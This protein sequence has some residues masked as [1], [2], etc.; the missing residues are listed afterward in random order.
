MKLKLKLCVFFIFFVVICIFGLENVKAAKVTG[1]QVT[2]LGESQPVSNFNNYVSTLYTGKTISEVCY[3]QQEDKTS[4]DKGKYLIIFSDGTASVGWEASGCNVGSSSGK[5]TDGV[6]KDNVNTAGLKNWSKNPSG[7]N[8]KVDDAYEAYKKNDYC[9]PFMTQEE[10][11]GANYFYLSTGGKASD[12]RY[13]QRK[14]SEYT[15]YNVGETASFT[16][17]FSCGYTDSEDGENE[18]F[19]LNFSKDGLVNADYTKDVKFQGN[20]GEHQLIK[21]DI[22]PRLTSNSYLRMLK[23]GKCP[24]TVDACEYGHLAFWPWDW[25]LGAT[26]GWV[27]IRIFGDSSVSKSFCSNDDSVNFYCMG[28]DCSE[29]DI[30]QVYD[31]YK[32]EILSTIDGYKSNKNF[33][34]KK[35]ILDEYNIL[36]EDLNGF[37]LSALSTLNYA[38]G[39]CV[40]QCIKLTKDIAEWETEAGIRTAGGNDKCNIGISIL[41]MVYNILKW[42]KYIVPAFIIIFSI[43]DFIKA[44]A[45]QNDDDMK[46]AQGKFV[47]RLIVAVLLFLLPLIIN[48]LLKTFGMYS[49]KCDITDLF[50]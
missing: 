9:P 16:S 21:L 39:N 47:K 32:T 40:S 26:N 31:D 42:A 36:K 43:L 48:F 35:A 13:I 44:I 17:D 5:C 29:D 34:A 15:Y 14:T 19:K 6:K 8:K 4:A 22:N 24:K 20:G 2:I 37:C 1:G 23:N 50:S 38:E 28:D 18:I 33:E 30:C 10:N 41:T 3:Y 49:S 11:W 7:V 46:K 27:D 12:L 45:A 25:V